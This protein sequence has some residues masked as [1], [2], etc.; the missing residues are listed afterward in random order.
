[1]ANCH[2]S[3]AGHVSE[4]RRGRRTYPIARAEDG[5]G[6]VGRID[7]A[8]VAFG[9]DRGEVCRMLLAPVEKRQLVS[10]H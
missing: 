10:S 2:V 6:Y 3:E 7:G 5:A 8:L 4:F 9:Q 1:M